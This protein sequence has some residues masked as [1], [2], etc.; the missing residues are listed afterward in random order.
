M[1]VNNV[2]ADKFGLDRK[3]DS[4]TGKDAEILDLL[5]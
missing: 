1:V 4:K 2:W 3:V 5:F